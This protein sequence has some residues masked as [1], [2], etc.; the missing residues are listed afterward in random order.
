AAMHAAY[1]WAI[2]EALDDAGIEIP[3]PQTDL[4]IRSVFGR[5]GDDALEALG[6]PAKGGGKRSTPPAGKKKPPQKAGQGSANDAAEDLLRPST[7][8]IDTEAEKDRA[9]RG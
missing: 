3:F 2:A 5:E 4:R 1:T 9:P 7:D 8:P 6:R